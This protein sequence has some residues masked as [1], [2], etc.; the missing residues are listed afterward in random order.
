MPHQLETQPL[1]FVADPLQPRLA[2]NY[3]LFVETVRTG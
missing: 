3:P 2:L 1:E